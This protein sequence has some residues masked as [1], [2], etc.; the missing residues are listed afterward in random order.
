MTD[1][2]HV[3]ADLVRATRFQFAL[4]DGYIAQALQ[5]FVVGD[6]FLPI[7]AIGVGLEDLAETLVAAHVRPDGAAVFR[8]IAPNQGN[9]LAVDGMLE[10]FFGQ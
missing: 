5:H 7:F 3:H 8:H 10:K 4:N 6:R 2:F 9:I 1:A